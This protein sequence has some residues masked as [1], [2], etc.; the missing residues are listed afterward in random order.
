M[1]YI[2]ILWLTFN[3]QNSIRASDQGGLTTQQFGSQQNC[4]YALKLIKQQAYY[5][6]GICVPSGLK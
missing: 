4:E 3:S 2:L 1:T 5:I 6:N